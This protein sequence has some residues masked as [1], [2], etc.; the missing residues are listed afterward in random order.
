MKALKFLVI[1]LGGILV[2]A[3]GLMAAIA[4]MFDA[5]WV[6]NELASIV[7]E[8]KQRTLRIDGDV[9]LSFWPSLGIRIGSVSLSEPR[10][11]EEFAALDA[12]R[13]S[14]AVLPL[15]S[16]QIVVDR[17]E[18]DGLRASLVRRRDGSLNFTDLLTGSKE[19]G[20]S[21]LPVQVAGIRIDNATL[22][23]RDEQS[24]K[25][26][27]VS[28]L[29]FATG[30]ISADAGTGIYK[31]DQVRLAASASS[32][33]DSLA[34]RLAI[35]GIEGN[36]EAVKLG[37]FDLQID[38][39][40]GDA[41]VKASLDAA[42]DV[43]AGLKALAIDPLGG[44]LEVG[45]PQLPMKTLRLPISGRLSADLGRS[46]ARAALNSHLDASTIALSV[47]VSRFSPPAVAFA[48]DVDQIDM[49][50]YLP[51]LQSSGSGKPAGKSGGGSIAAAPLQGLDLQGTVS[52]G[53]LQFAGIQTSNVRLKVNTRGGQLEYTGMAQEALKAKVEEQVK[54]K[55]Q[56]KIQDLLFGR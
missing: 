51:T 9:A 31:V 1:V 34:L 11:T 12:A 40:A 48:L 46:S 27:V 56:E 47:T 19:D 30:P 14:V 49:D 36:A 3:L 33:T 25:T 29:D 38:G 15:L 32:G 44:S 7:Q 26:T 10:S 8:Q 28:G 53:R 55:A 23:W 13:V 5:A 6:K 41:T 54:Q 45:H 39:R 52:I 17:I 24:G 42:I 37:K 35:P 20:R 16:R 18:V 50:R 4:V 2:L 21:P 22:S 43:R